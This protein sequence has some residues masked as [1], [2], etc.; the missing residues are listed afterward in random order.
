MS[1]SRKLIFEY[2]APGGLPLRVYLR[3]DP[4]EI[5]ISVDDRHV[6]I[7]L[8]GAA[9]LAK[10]LHTAALWPL[11]TAA[12]WPRSSQHHLTRQH[13]EGAAR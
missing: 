10:L 4:D 2:E 8:A 5:E 1:S 6:L 7:T 11:Y 9:R 3:R 13:R 12:L